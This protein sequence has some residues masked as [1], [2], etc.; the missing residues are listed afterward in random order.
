MARP[1]AHGQAITST[2]T[3]A[4]IAASASLPV[5]SQATKVATAIT[6]HD[7]DEHGGDLVGQPLD[8]RLAGLRVHH[9]LPDPG[10][11]GVPARSG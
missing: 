2:L 1:S 9:R 4:V 8:R 5:S 11:Q 3:A 6:E 10:E 7:R